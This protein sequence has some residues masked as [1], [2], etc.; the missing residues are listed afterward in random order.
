MLPLARFII[1]ITSAFL[2]ARSVF[3]LAPAFLARAAFFA[4]L[5]FLPALRAPSGFAVSGTGL[6]MLSLSIAFSF[7]EFLPDRVAIVTFIT[8]V[9]RKSKQYL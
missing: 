8:P 2:L 5:A 6:L 1:S 4:G 9:R 7:F 3:G